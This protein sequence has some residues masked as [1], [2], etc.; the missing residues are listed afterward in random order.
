[1]P[2][3]SINLSQTANN[4][5]NYFELG[6]QSV[7]RIVIGLVYLILSSILSILYFCV[8][9]LMITDKN[10]WKYS[11]HKLIINL[12]VYDLI[13]LNL[14]GVTG[15]I[16]NLT[17]GCPFW[18]NKISGSIM[19]ASW[20]VSTA[21]T[22]LLAINRFVSVLLPN[23]M[24]RVFSK[25]ATNLYVTLLLTYGL[26]WFTA[27]QF[28]GMNIIYFLGLNSWNFVDTPRGNLGALLN[29]SIDIVHILCMFFW[30]SCVYIYL[31]LKVSLSISNSFREIG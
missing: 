20:F 23:W 19:N 11:F 1:M 14:T 8:M 2:N 29:M 12:S 26:C 13:Q 31:K 3:L 7:E 6:Q 9:Y 27:H 21:N 25:R 22:H 10:Q 28:L 18:F 4:V 17:N 5:S 30:Y 15:G 24:I 16:F